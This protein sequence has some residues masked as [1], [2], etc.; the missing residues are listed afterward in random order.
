MNSIDTPRRPLLKRKS[1]RIVLLI[2]V[3]AFAAF[4]FTRPAPPPPPRG[5]GQPMQAIVYYEYGSPDVLRLEEIEKLLPNENQVLIKVRAAAANP[6]DW[7]YIRGVPYIIRL[8]DSG[9]R[10]PKDPRV[11]VD[12]AGVIEAVGSSVT[13]FKPGDEVFGTGNGAFAQYVLASQKRITLKPA[14]LTF[15]QAAAVPVAAVTALQGLR[16]KGKLQAGQKVLINGASGGVGTFA[17]QI[18]KSMGAEVT[19]VCSTRNIELVRSLGAD[20]VIDYTKEDLAQGAQRY[21]V[22]L[23]NVGTRPLSDFKR[24]MNPNGVYVLIGGGGPEDNGLI[25]PMKGP[26]KAYMLSLVSSQEFGSMI[27]SVNPEDLGLL[28]EMMTTK[29]VTPVIDRT[30]NSLSEVPDA[31]RYLETGRARGKVIVNVQSTTGEPA[32]ERVSGAAAA[33]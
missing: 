33:Q 13:K 15:E 18:A 28:S 31:I 22:V 1:T 2:V 14:E 4:W 5:S 8:I 32:V 12:M 24:V 25:G 23:D 16:D 26:I 17:V 11:G 20:H 30:Y 7:H 10:K 19:G 29:K 9:L 27:A 21:D 6:L 3:A